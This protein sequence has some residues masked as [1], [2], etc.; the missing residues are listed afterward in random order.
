MGGYS[1]H[2]LPSGC[3]VASYFL[4]WGDVVLTS[5]AVGTPREKR[6][7][8]APKAEPEASGNPSSWRIAVFTAH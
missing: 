7:A 6:H 1:V 5:L 2:S 3:V 4:G 8:H